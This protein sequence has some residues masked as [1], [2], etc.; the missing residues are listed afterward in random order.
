VIADEELDSSEPILCN[1]VFFG[2]IGSGL[3]ENVL[4]SGGAGGGGRKNVLG[5]GGAGGGGAAGSNG[6]TGGTKY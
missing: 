5:A 4:D 6:V 2:V 3:G 1:P